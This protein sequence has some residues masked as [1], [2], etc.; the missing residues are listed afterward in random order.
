MILNGFEAIDKNLE[1]VFSL[2]N[3]GG[4]TI[5]KNK[6]IIPISVKFK[7]LINPGCELGLGAP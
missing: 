4:L 2:T 1:F 6:G 3:I 5:F 7:R